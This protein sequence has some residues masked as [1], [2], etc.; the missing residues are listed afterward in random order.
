MIPP[1]HVRSAFGCTVP[2]VPLPGGEGEVSRCGDIVLKPC[3]DAEE[4]AWVAELHRELTPDGF[5]LPHPVRASSGAWVVDG[6][7]AWTLVEGH[8]ARSRWPE[9]IAACRAF[10]RST[11]TVAMPAFLARRDSPFAR[12][13][14][15]AWGEE[16]PEVAHSLR[17]TVERLLG[18]L[19]P[20]D[21]PSQLIHG[22][23]TENV[24]FADGQPPAVIDITPYW[25]PAAYAQAIIV[26]D[27]LDWYGADRSILDLVADVPEIHQLMARAELFRIAILDG[28]HRQG[29]DTLGA[30]SGHQRTV[31]MLAERLGKSQEVGT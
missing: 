13:D 7:Q 11:T 27:A 3:Q 16:P 10:H 22:D 4:A 9:V 31:G 19:E 6:W 2:P 18:L 12:A 26:A 5:R 8:H 30:I 21:L 23:F 14:R 1:E 25:R 17:P 29:A 15:I 28:L 24:L 20:V